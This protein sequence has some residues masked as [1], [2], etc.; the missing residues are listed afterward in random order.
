M[1]FHFTI[2]A[3]LFTCLFQ[4]VVF[5]Q[6]IQFQSFLQNLVDRTKVLRS[7]HQNPQTPSEPILVN[8]GLEI[9]CE[10]PYLPSLYGLIPYER[11]ECKKNT[12]G[13]INLHLL[14]NV[15][16]RGGYFEPSWVLQYRRQAP[17]DVGDSVYIRT[18]NFKYIY[19]DDE[20]REVS[21]VIP[22][23]A[24]IALFF[25]DLNYSSDMK[26][27]S[28]MMSY[29]I[30]ASEAP[31]NN[32][33]KLDIAPAAEELGLVPT[34]SQQQMVVTSPPTQQSILYQSQQTDRCPPGIPEYDYTKQVLR[35]CGNVRDTENHQ[36]SALLSCWDQGKLSLNA[37]HLTHYQRYAG[38]K[39]PC[40]LLMPLQ[41]VR[42]SVKDQCPMQ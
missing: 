20:G 4:K 17:D 33:K 9:S 36:N 16:Q 18:K 24:Y 40:E 32:F 10:V 25:R 27:F 39:S 13:R 3:L 28:G 34:P 29:K 22:K 8:Q 42:D 30:Y 1:K 19:I 7:V 37:E 35:E 23:D 2:L 21:W 11:M 12:L 38:V 31:G 14:Q 5:A 6:T 41:C 26:T 15:F